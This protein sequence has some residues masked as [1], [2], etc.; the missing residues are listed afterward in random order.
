MK[1]ITPTLEI[2]IIET[3]N[4]LAVSKEQFE[5]EETNGV[6]NIIFD[7]INLFS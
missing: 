3:E 1:Y 7:A 6:G 5:I 2:A 4:I